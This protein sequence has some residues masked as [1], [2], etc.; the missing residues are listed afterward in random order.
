MSV[1]MSMESLSHVWYACYGS[2][3]SFERFSCY[4]RGGTPPGAERTYSGCSDTTLPEDRRQY[5]IRHRLYFARSSPIWQNGGVAFIDP[6]RD[7]ARSTLG[8]IYRITTDQ[9]VQVVRQENGLSPDDHEIEMDIR[10]IIDS[11][12]AVVGTGWYSRLMVLGSLD[13]IPILTFTSP[14]ISQ[15]SQPGS[16]YL[17]TIRNG[18]AE[19]Y[20]TLTGREITEYLKRAI[21]QDL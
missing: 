11:G 3:L 2:N 9:F 18:L 5:T 15:P 4:I 7:D 6:L 17:R 16:N 8:M 13:G 14:E 19:S 1:V 10:A 12:S 20:P 21:D